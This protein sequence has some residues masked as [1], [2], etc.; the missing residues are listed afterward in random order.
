MITIA[1]LFGLLL[2]VSLGLQTG[3]AF[4][5]PAKPEVRFSVAS[6]TT[7][8]VHVY[9]PE[10]WG[11]LHMNVSNLR[12]EPRELLVATYFDA[13]PTLQF[14]RR[15][16]LP[17]R[18]SLHTTQ[19]VRIPKLDPKL[20]RALNFHTLVLD[21]E[22]SQ[23]VLLKDDSGKLLNDGAVLVSHEKRISAMIEDRRDFT[24]SESAMPYELA[25]AC[26]LSQ[27]LDRR[28]TTLA[29]EGLPYDEHSLQALDHLVVTGNRL[30]EDP[31]GL[32]AVRQWLHGGGRLWVMLD[33]TD[34]RVLEM[35]LG[36]EL[37]CHVIDR[38]G[39]TS[40][41]IDPVNVGANKSAEPT[42]DHEVPVDLLRVAA[43]DVE[44]THAVNGWPAAFWKTCG[45]GRLLVTTLGPRGWMTRK[46]DVASGASGAL[47]AAASEHSSPFVPLTPMFE[48]AGRFLM[49]RTPE[50]IPPSILAPEVSEHIGYSIP[51]RGVVLGLLLG[52]VAVLVV[53][54]AWLWR[55]GRLEHFGWIGP[56]VGVVSGAALILIGHFNRHEIPASVSAMQFV[57]MLPGTD[58]VRMQGL[59]ATYHPEGSQ[60]PIKSLQGGRLVPD[61]TG[62]VG[63]ARR[64]IWT[65]LE[66]WQWDNVP[67][68][69]GQVVVPF[70]QSKA[71]PKRVEVRA[72]LGP[73]G[74]TGQL[75]A[76]LPGLSD[77][78]VVARSGRIGVQLKPGGEFVASANN[79]FSRDQY[80]DAQLLNDEQS[81]RRRV[82]QK[83]LK[84]PQRRD[85]PDRPQFMFWTDPWPTGLDL[86]DGL[87]SHGATLCTIPLRLDRPAVGHEFVIPAPL[88]PFRTV[89]R[90]DGKPSSQLWNHNFN[91]WQ[92][93]AIY[94]STWLRFQVP[95][96]I[97][98]IATNRGRLV[99][100]VSGPI[101]RFE[102][103]GLD[104]GKVVSLGTQI[105]PVGT[106][107][108]DI[109][110]LKVLGLS[111]DGGLRLG[112]N[113]GDRSRPELTK[114]SG[115]E[116]GKTNYWRIES[117]SL[118]LWGRA[119]EN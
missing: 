103:L 59:V 39:L 4:A 70:S 16:W 69:A 34:P 82:L 115:D 7:G 108:F 29:Y 71:L 60:T 63:T 17:P 64:M 37:N 102:L 62:L 110:D 31:A 35:L 45:D 5:Q 25:I 14:G 72:A 12:D 26:R 74:L 97:L 104:Q 6:A 101:G 76:D 8:G 61:M 73:E 99:V 83:L 49:I 93:S 15:I 89:H 3:A 18:S 86:G 85:Y 23:E 22:D 50:L 58:D 51:A 67:Q 1:R 111:S 80:L 32:A 19:P 10:K 112:M 95:S 24:N 84:N 40:V 38:V 33:R 57:Q 47:T 44:V 54:G 94:S 28:L 2:C 42:I 87:K 116:A 36:D 100:T 48:I 46:S 96:E 11:L 77:A 41:R 68:V 21:A 118:T 30:L 78:A 20:G 81:R 117:L 9:S 55:R 109:S 66:S 53:V 107:S 106:L 79:V 13:E 52:F 119:V 88:L 92:E 65:D 105:D 90:P 98:P 75:S 113:I 56:V 27:Q 114:A 91:E 43:S